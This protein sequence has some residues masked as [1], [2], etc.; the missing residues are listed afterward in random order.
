M[1][2]HRPH[3]HMGKELNKWEERKREP[4]RFRQVTYTKSGKMVVGPIQERKGR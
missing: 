3:N 2:E 4:I 1:A